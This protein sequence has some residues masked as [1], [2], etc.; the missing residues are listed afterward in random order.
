MPS[1]QNSISNGKPEHDQYM[2]LRGRRG[3]TSC[4]FSSEGVWDVIK[5]GRLIVFLSRTKYN[6]KRIHHPNQIFAM[7]LYK[8][9]VSLIAA[10]AAASCAA[11]SATPLRRRS[12]DG[13]TLSTSNSGCN[14][15]SPQC[16][17]SSTGVAGGLLLA[18]CTASVSINQW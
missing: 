17:N 5:R 1:K 9:I 18:G 15:G 14:T 13:Y 7:M 12:D 2:L 16:C 11:A 3:K 6:F 8:P 10:F 4:H